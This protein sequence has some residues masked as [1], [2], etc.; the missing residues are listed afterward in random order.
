MGL[1]IR[2]LIMRSLQVSK[3]R[4]PVFKYLYHF[5][6]L[7]TSNF[8]PLETAIENFRGLQMSR[9]VVIITRC[10]GCWNT[11][12]FPI[13]V[14]S[15]VL[16]SNIEHVEDATFERKYVSYKICTLFEIIVYDGIHITPVVMELTEDTG[17]LSHYSYWSILPYNRIQMRLRYIQH[18]KFSVEF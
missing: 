6:I 9:G 8:I 16:Y 17:V 14:S 11:P 15:R 7:Q 13:L 1:W 2:R 3:S 4:H 5:E 12:S 18:K 10:I